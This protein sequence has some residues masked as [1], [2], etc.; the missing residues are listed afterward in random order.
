[1]KHTKKTDLFVRKDFL[2]LWSTQS[3]SQL[4]S[5]MTAVTLTTCSYAPYVIMSIFAG[6]LTDRFSK[7][8]LMLGCDLGG[9]LLCLLT[10]RKLK[11]YHFR[12]T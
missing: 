11:N 3:V 6:A 12:E 2:I 8:K 9:T 1:M 5:S 10:G 4:G 7:K